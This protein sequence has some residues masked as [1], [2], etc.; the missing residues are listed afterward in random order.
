MNLGN[1]LNFVAS[2]DVEEALV[3]GQVLSTESPNTS[4]VESSATYHMCNM[5][6]LF[7]EYIAFQKPGEVPVVMVMSWRLLIVVQLI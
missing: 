5:K 2:N 3:A 6:E 4:I 7:V 1:A